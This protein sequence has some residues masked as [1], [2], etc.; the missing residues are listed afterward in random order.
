MTGRTRWLL[1]G[2]W[3]LP[4]LVL[5]AGVH[6]G[7]PGYAL[8][9]VPAFA[10]A[11]AGAVAKD[12]LAMPLAV[13][14]AAAAIAFFLFAPLH[15]LGTWLDRYRAAA[16]VPTADSIRIQ[17]EEARALSRIT[18]ACPSP[19]CTIVSLGTADELWEHDPASLRRWYAGD[20]RVVRLSELE[21][22]GPL[23]D[24]AFWIGGR[25]PDVVPRLARRVDDVGLWE[26]YRTRGAETARLV[27]RL[28]TRR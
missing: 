9:C 14:L 10:V 22:S 28:S 4:Y 5:Y 6:F 21:G 8:A 16:F 25:V 11:A 3:V 13:V 20:A 15:S 19:S 7:K 2:A 24:T 12:R 18:R 17:D 23:G 26:V 27:N 1:L